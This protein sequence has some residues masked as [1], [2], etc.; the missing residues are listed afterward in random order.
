[1]F[2]KVLSLISRS[3]KGKRWSP[4]RARLRLESLEDRVVPST[5]TMSLGG[6]LTVNQ[7]APGH[8]V[9]ITEN[10]DGSITVT[11]NDALV[12]GSH[13]FGVQSIRFN[14]QAAPCGSTQV[15]FVNKGGP[16]LAGSVTVNGEAGDSLVV[17]FGAT[18]S[19]AA[20]SLTPAFSFN[21]R[22]FVTVTDTAATSSLEVNAFNSNFGSLTASAGGNGSS[23]ILER[24]TI[25]TL[26]T[27]GL[28]SGGNF[29]GGTHDVTELGQDSIGSLSVTGSNG[30]E[31]V[32]DFLNVNG[33]ASVGFSGSK[34]DIVGLEAAVNIQGSLS[35]GTGSGNDAVVG[36]LVTVG[37]STTIKTGNA[38]AGDIVLMQ[39]LT[40]RQSLSVTTGSGNDI[41]ALA[42]VEVDGMT[43]INTGNAPTGDRVALTSSTFYGAVF[44]TFGTGNDSLFIQ[45]NSGPIVQPGGSTQFFASVSVNM[46]TGNDTLDMANTPTSGTVTFALVASFN[47]G[48]GNDTATYTGSLVSGAPP[49]FPNFETVNVL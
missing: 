23:V 30:D 47:G 7:T 28:G 2:G 33:N 34:S 40:E 45:S 19:S 3:R 29:N 32:A 8:T 42:L 12:G 36:E 4:P 25:S 9:T 14:D 11:S 13:F 16:I 20:S 41:V 10:K 22:G 27:I 24:D 17:D 26:A 6:T 49:I 35:I 38:P 48:D 21:V 44:M 39:A 5:V 18:G 15:D 31:L 46:G 37:G 43:T 1:M